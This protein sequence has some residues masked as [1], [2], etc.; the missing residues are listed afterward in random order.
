M[1]Q[2]RLSDNELKDIAVSAGATIDPKDARSML[3]SND[4]Q[5]EVVFAKV[6]DVA[7]RPLQPVEKANETTLVPKQSYLASGLDSVGKF[8]KSS[9]SAIVP[10]DVG[11]VTQ[12]MSDLAVGAGTGFAH[13]VFSGGDLIRRATGM[14]RIID[15]P[16]V[17]ALIT[18]PDSTA[19]RL[20]YGLEQVGEFFVPAKA[21]LSSVK[22]ASKLPQAATVTARLARALLGASAEGVGAAGVTALQGG[23]KKDAAATGLLTGGMTIAAGPFAKAAGESAKYLGERIERALLKPT[24]FVS[25]GLTPKQIVKKVYE[26]GVG[27]NLE[28][29]MQKV[30]QKIDTLRRNLQGVLT[31]SSQQGAGVSLNQVAADTLNAYTGNQKAQDAIQRISDQIEFNLNA[32]GKQINTGVMDLL[33]AN[34]AK[35]AVGD[36]GAWTHGFAG[37]VISDADRILEKVAN[38][39]YSKLKTAIELGSSG[40]TQLIN[41]KL[42]DLIM[43]RGAFIRRI[44]I[45]QRSNVLSINDL[46]A[47]SH[48]NFGLSI[49][50]HLLKS[51]S[52]ANAIESA[53][54]AVSRSAPVL[55]AVVGRL[56]GAVPSVLSRPT[57]VIGTDEGQ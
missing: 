1:A 14:N 47:L 53:G 33:D 19:G 40:P 3:F 37:N 32:Q 7:S 22:I 54:S 27:G 41:K 30:T 10:E 34:T 6:A 4:K 26:Y 49:A 12:K 43:L 9:V 42:S 20:G 28:T 57:P 38:T 39:Y 16:D 44:P 31:H 52:F 18:P 45:E 24:T 21:G 51:G 29:S 17:K 5:R 56:A 25:E 11:A 2:R 15:E 55:G 36:M 35:Q 48:H 50:G 13:T 23:D 46:L 8:A